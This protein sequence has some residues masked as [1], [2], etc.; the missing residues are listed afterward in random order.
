MMKY[1]EFLAIIPILFTVCFLKKR[2]DLH[3]HT[4]ERCISVL[5]SLV[6]SVLVYIMLVH[7]N[8]NKW[9]AIT[10]SLILWI[11]FTFMKKRVCNLLHL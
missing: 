2:E 3:K 10:I 4:I 7:Y 11:I 1:I 9:I 6:I 8:V 5:I